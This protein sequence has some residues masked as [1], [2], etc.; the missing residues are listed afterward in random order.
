M[1]KKLI[2][3]KMK[4]FIWVLFIL[5]LV[6]LINVIL[7]KGGMVVNMVRMRSQYGGIQ[8]S[9]IDR[10]SAINFIPFKT[11]IYYLSQNEGGWNS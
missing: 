11:I 3:K 2:A 5:Y 9:F 10:I 6:M 8:S 4:L 7:L 1:E